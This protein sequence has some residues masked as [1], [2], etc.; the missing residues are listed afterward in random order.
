[1]RTELWQNSRDKT[2]AE[3]MA[4]QLYEQLNKQPQQPDF[5]SQ[6]QLFRQNPIQFL[7]QKNVNVPNE[8]MNDPRSA[9]NYLVQNGQMN[10]GA[11]QRVMG[12]LQRMGF[13]F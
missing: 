7:M 13:R 4:N 3:R 1:M 5:Q 2:E 12:T 10:Q 6:F 8:M 9:V 11:L